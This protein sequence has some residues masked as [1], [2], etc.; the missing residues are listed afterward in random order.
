MPSGSRMHISIFKVCSKLGS[1]G[2]Y[3]FGSAANTLLPLALVPVFTRYLTPEDYGLVATATV[4]VNILTLLTGSNV[5]GLIARTQFESDPSQ[6]RGIIS[7]A[8]WF[9]SGFSLLLGLLFLTP[10]GSL[11]AQASQFPFAWL[12]SVVILAFFTAIQQNYQTLLQARKE[13]W[14]FVGNITIGNI[15]SI[16]LSV[17]LVVGFGWNWEGRMWGNLIGGGLVTGLCLWGLSMRLGLLRL[18]FS[19]ASFKEILRFGIPLIPHTVGGWVMT[20][21]PRLYLNNLAS[22]ADT[23][24]FSLAFNLTAPLGMLFGAFNKTYFPWLFEKLSN[25]SELD[26]VALCRK[27][28]MLGLVFLLGGIIFGLLAALALPMLVGPKF[29]G[30]APYVFWLS[31]AASLQGVY[32]IFGNFIIF[33]KKTHLMAWRIDFLGGIAVVASC[34]LLIWWVGPVGAAIANCFGFLVSLIGCIT[35]M[36]QAHPMPWREAASPRSLFLVLRSWFAAPPRP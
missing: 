4:L 36:Q 5:Y 23:G 6:L 1:A 20:M 8:T 14:R 31:V 29:Y 7:T 2:I 24:L 27:L 17:W 22:V 30:A 15:A 26:A 18:E 3:F 10:L 21:S 19:K 33:A 34:P 28:L 35:A 25:P 12:P 9:T 11:T 16:A 32:F 13:P